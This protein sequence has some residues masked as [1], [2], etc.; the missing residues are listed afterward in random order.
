MY[1]QEQNYKN[2]LK[3][4]MKHLKLYTMALPSDKTV[5]THLSNKLAST[6][7][8]VQSNIS[9]SFVHAPS[10]RLTGTRASD[11]QT[12]RRPKNIISYQSTSIQIQG[13]LINV[14]YAH[15]IYNKYY[16]TSK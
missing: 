4:V 6:Q 3:H 2:I 10:D 14:I 8:W 13:P 7:L 5:D 15:I 16:N 9:C 11:R 1:L 12:D